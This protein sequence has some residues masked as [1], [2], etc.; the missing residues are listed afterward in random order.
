MVLSIRSSVEFWSRRQF[1]CTCNKN[2]IPAKAFPF[3]KVKIEA[4]ANSGKFFK[5]RI[6]IA[7]SLILP[8]YRMC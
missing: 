5:S 3:E 4:A 7:Y 2:H 8:A 6:A 1:D